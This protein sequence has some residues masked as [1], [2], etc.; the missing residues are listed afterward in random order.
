MTPSPQ[1]QAFYDWIQHG[2]GSCILEAV[3]D[4]K[5]RLVRGQIHP[6][7]LSTTGPTLPDPEKRAITMLRELSAKDFPETG[8]LIAPD[9]SFTPR[10]P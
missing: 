5:G 10:P 4:G 1:Q 3:L 8:P 9:G 2:A 7:L 6:F